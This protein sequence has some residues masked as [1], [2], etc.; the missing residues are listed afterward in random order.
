MLMTDDDEMHARVM[1][2][3]DHGREPGDV[4]FKNTYR[5]DNPLIM[6]LFYIKSIISPT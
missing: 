4:H 1:H 5:V 6:I 2:L 3:R